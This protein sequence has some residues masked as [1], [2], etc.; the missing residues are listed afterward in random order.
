MIERLLRSSIQKSLSDTPKKEIAVIGDTIGH[1][2]GA[3]SDRFYAD[4]LDKMIAADKVIIA[5]D[6]PGRY[7]RMICLPG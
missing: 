2:H 1:Y 7:D 3:V 5:Q 4:R 6:A